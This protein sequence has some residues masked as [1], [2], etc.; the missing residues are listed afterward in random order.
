MTARQPDLFAPASGPGSALPPGLTYRPELIAPAEE[1]ALAA[2][3]AGLELRPFQFHGYEGKRR[4]ASFGARYDFERE[5]LSPAA[6]IPEFLTPLRDRCAALAGI[7][8]E[9]FA[10]ALVTEYAPGAAIGWH[11]DKAVFGVVAG[12]SLLSPCTFRL[13]RR[14]GAKWRRASFTAEPRS[15]YLLTG[16]ARR[17]WEHSIPPVQALRWSVTFRTLRGDGV[18]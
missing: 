16:E 17:E 12:V 9:A 7:R 3:L 14:D 10:H 1:Q 18:E 11:R 6:P 8:P 5:A 15:A 4:V 13:R 2:A